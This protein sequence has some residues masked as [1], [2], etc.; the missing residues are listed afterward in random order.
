MQRIKHISVYLNYLAG[1]GMIRSLYW[2]TQ[3]ITITRDTTHQQ[4]LSWTNINARHQLRGSLNEPINISFE[5]LCSSPRD[6][7]PTDLKLGRPYINRSSTICLMLMYY[8][9]VLETSKRGSVLRGC[10]FIRFFFFAKKE[11]KWRH[12]K[13]TPVHL[14]CQSIVGGY[15]IDNAI[16]IAWAIRI[17]KEPI[18]P[19]CKEPFH[20]CSLFIIDGTEAMFIGLTP[21]RII[22][23]LDLWI[24]NGRTDWWRARNSSYSKLVTREN[25]VGPRQDDTKNS[26]YSMFTP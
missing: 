22:P 8:R 9:S 21:R 15:V 13:A 11:R 4:P 17:L 20:L 23:Q 16:C 19:W 18:S 10:F 24:N 3:Q 1:P 6:L 5:M 26:N 12:R 14:G 2:P 25:R 7:L